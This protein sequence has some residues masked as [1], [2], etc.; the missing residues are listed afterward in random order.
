MTGASLISVELVAGCGFLSIEGNLDAM[1]SIYAFSYFL[2][3]Q[4]F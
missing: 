1:A 3:C 4:S 2:D